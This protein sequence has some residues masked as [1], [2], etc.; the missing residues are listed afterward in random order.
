MIFS[1]MCEAGVAYMEEAFVNW[2][3]VDKTVVA[4]E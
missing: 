2:D 1:K 4:D 3:P